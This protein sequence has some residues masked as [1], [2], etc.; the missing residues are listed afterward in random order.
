MIPI[1]YF[2]VTLLLTLLTICLVVFDNYLY[3]KRIERNKIKKKKSK[4]KNI[5]ELKWPDWLPR[6]LNKSQ[7]E[8]ENAR[9]ESERN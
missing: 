2:L 3:L 6:Y 1:K 9:S 5:Y 4:N 8:K 7:K